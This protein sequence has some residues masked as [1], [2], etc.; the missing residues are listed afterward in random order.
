MDLDFYD[1][2]YRPGAYLETHAHH[3][4]RWHPGKQKTPSKKRTK[5]ST[6]KK[7]IRKSR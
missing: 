5:P 2:H 1:H 7:G 6:R 3:M 4:E